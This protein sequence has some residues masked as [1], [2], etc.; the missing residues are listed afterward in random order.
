MDKQIIAQTLKT[1]KDNSPKRN[2]KQSIDLIINLKE[3]DLKKAEHQINSF[4]T[5]PFST[6]RA[7]SVCA[8]VGPELEGN[9]KE[10]C[11][12]VISQD[13]FER[14]KG[15]KEIKKLART[16]DYFV[17]QANIM[18]KVAT[19]FGRFL[20]PKGKMPNPKIGAV[21]PPNANLRPSYDTLKRTVPV[22]TKNE[23]RAIWRGKRKC[24]QLIKEK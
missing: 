9:A 19:I 16:H 15:K 1:L 18:P 10:V 6:G 24:A 12:E 2:F 23:E 8:F 22:A 5:L 7:V 20:G 3:L 14:F 4:V 11:D 17:S 21:V 13:Q